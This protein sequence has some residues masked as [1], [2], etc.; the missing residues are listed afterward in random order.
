MGQAEPSGSSWREALDSGKERRVRDPGLQQYNRITR[1]G[2]EAQLEIGCR[3]LR[4]HLQRI[5]NL[6]CHPGQVI[7]LLWASRS[8]LV[9]ERH[10][11][12]YLILLLSHL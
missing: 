1:S 5:S 9:R 3:A 7:A 6:V 8:T 10:C 11:L 12:D 2:S 4:S